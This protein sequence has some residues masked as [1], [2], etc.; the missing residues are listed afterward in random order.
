MPRKPKDQMTPEELES[1]REYYRNYQRKRKENLSDSELKEHKQIT[2]ERN[3]KYKEVNKETL[4]EK[5]KVYVIN[6]EDKIKS[7][8][9]EYYAKNKE[10]LSTKKKEYYANN[11]EYVRNYKTQRRL[12]D[13]LYRLTEN[14]RNLIRSSL[15]RKN[16][17]KRS[18]TEKI[19]GCS[20][21]D[22]KLHVESLWEPW[23]SWENYGL[24]NGELNY[25]WD[26][27]HIVP[28]SSGLNEEGVIVL[29]HYTNLKPLCSKVNRDIKRANPISV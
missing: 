19:L 16:H 25:G 6:N 9:Q 18:N 23:M 1:L 13:P 7:S 12:T 3:K 15:R 27:D 20:F 11:K 10:Q 2:A 21:E 26:I 28:V 4:K 24:Y 22:F 5:R 17:N 14:I 8:W 29:N